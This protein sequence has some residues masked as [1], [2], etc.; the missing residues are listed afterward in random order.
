VKLNSES[1]PDLSANFVKLKDNDWLQKQR[2]AG[3]VTA[4]ALS[5]LEHLVKEKTTKSLLELDKIVEDFIIKNECTPTFKHY[6]GF[7]NSCCFSV[8][9][10]MVHGVATDYIL[11]DGDLISFD[12]GATYKGSVADSAIT[13][14][15]GNARDEEHTKLLLAC[16]EALMKGIEAIGIGMRLGCIGRAIYK[17]AQSTGYNVITQYGGHGICNHSDGSPMPHAQPFVSNKSMPNE[18]IRFQPGLTLAIEPML[19]IGSN[20]T[21]VDKDGWTV[22]GKGMSAHFEHTVFIHENYT[23]IITQ[24]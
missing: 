13:C 22:Y 24:R 21:Y 23:E 12:L 1:H 17:Y 20:E 4:G 7:P 15:F 5:L 11:K 6:K 8:N 3:K 10:Q 2:I 14:I 18:G 19:M 9:Y 16:Q